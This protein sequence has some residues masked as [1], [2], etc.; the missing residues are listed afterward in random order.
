M[1]RALDAHQQERAR[2][3]HPH[4]ADDI[5]WRLDGAFRAQRAL[6]EPGQLQLDQHE[7]QD[8]GHQD[9]GDR[10]GREPHGLR[11]VEQNFSSARYELG[12]SGAGS[13]A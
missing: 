3:R 4:Q 1:Q 6:V 5:V 13:N 9:D 2:I 8:T 12:R 7:Q 11:P 10:Q